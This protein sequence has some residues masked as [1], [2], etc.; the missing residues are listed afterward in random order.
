VKLDGE[1]EAPAF[2]AQAEAQ[3]KGF[4]WLGSRLLTT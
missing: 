2:E 1:E 3:D 4:P